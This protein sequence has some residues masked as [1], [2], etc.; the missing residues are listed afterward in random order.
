MK[1]SSVCVF[2]GSKSGARPEYVDAARET[3][4]ALADR[5]ITI[6]YGGGHV[7]MMGALADAAL[8]CGGRIVGIIPRHLMR[9]EIAHRGLSELVIVDSMHA[10]KRAMA[11][12]SDAFLGLPGGFGT[13]EELFE[14]L[15][16]LQ[17]QL[18]RKPVGVYNV[19]G[20]FAPLARFLEHAVAEEF[21]APAHADL[22]TVSDS[23]P[24]LLDSL[25]ARL[26]S[27]QTSASFR[28][29]LA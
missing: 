14:M 27:D 8:E 12:R 29:D 6:V 18:E 19:A 16:W 28:S 24:A 11:D 3:A 1:L 21:I 22:L 23:L 13:I 10:R 25:T 4:R 17:L 20:F 26:G 5:D 2:C 7:G 9:P 15:T